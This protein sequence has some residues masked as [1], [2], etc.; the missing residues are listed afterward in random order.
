MAFKS[1]FERALFTCSSCVYCQKIPDDINGNPRWI[2]TANPPQWEHN[3]DP[4]SPNA[5]V[6]PQVEP[7]TFAC[8]FFKSEY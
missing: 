6:Y 2:C 1:N 4:L 3:T 8:R 7:K 5:W